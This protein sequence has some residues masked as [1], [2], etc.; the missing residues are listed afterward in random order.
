VEADRAVVLVHGIG[1]QR[2]GTVLTGFGGAVVDWLQA[3]GG[4]AVA[5]GD[6][7]DGADGRPAWADVTVTAGPVGPS[8]RIRMVEAHWADVVR[9]PS[10]VQLVVWAAR[11][12]PAAVTHHIGA[13]IATYVGRTRQGLGSARPVERLIGAVRALAFLPLL[14]LLVLST[15]VL[16]PL[17]LGLLVVTLLLG[18]VGTAF[19]LAAS[20]AA[21]LQRVLT[22]TLGDTAYLLSNAVQQAY[23]RGRVDEAIDVAREAVAD[24][25]HV[26]VVAHSQGAAVAHDALARRPAEEAVHLITLGQGHAKIERLR[27]RATSLLM[28][29][30]SIAMP[31]VIVLAYAELRSGRIAAVG[32]A[33][34]AVLAAVVPPLAV[35][36]LV[37]V[38]IAVLR[39]ASPRA[40]HQLQVALCLTV[41]VDPPAP[42]ARHPLAAATG[43]APTRSVWQDLLAGMRPLALRGLVVGAGAAAAAVGVWVDDVMAIPDVVPGP[44]LLLV[45]LLLL[46]TVSSLALLWAQRRRVPVTWPAGARTWTDIWAS[47][48]PVPNGPLVTPPGWEDRFTDVEVVNHGSALLDHTTYFR[49]ATLVLPTIVAR[50][51]PPG[52]ALRTT[53]DG[54][55]DDLLADG[56]ER[57]RRLGSWA[58]GS[59]TAGL[60]VAAAVIV[61]GR[62]PP[63]IGALPADRLPALPAWAPMAGDV[64][65]LLG[66]ALA[67]FAV[68]ALAWVAGRR[69]V[70]R[71][72]GARIAAPAATIDLAD[73]ARPA[74]YRAPP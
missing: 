71:G 14:A 54:V 48:D 1:G 52:W 28:A 66:S 20:V 3:A 56:I 24:P 18:A 36:G 73:A 37:L 15:G 49:N 9:A 4:V 40:R 7:R 41:G 59:R 13:I 42:P 51:L 31:I 53:A 10:F 68:W 62:V 26:V 74:G 29:L 44:V 46:A 50:L 60:A 61:S 34:S 72:R 45:N 8:V 47:A 38:L 64:D 27:T 23:V 55:A 2:R 22:G 25:A 5:V 16:T 58:W 35:F 19:P 6:A 57:S 65:R 17:V 11:V 21:G 32:D 70:L 30:P 12:L 39:S 69:L 67:G 63:L 43:I 33:V